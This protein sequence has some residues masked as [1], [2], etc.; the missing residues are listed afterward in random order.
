LRGY[1][2]VETADGSNSLKK[3]LATMI[4]VLFTQKS[5]RLL[6]RRDLTIR[7]ADAA[8]MSDR[9]GIYDTDFP[10]LAAGHLRP[11]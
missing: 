7:P 11:I 9:N 5:A 2:L 3:I 10:T 8:L 6:D 1:S 4:Q